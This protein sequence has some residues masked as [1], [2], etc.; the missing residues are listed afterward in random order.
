MYADDITLWVT[1]G[2]DAELEET[3][4]LGVHTVCTIAAQAGLA[5]SP[6]KSALLLL[7]P[8][9]DRSH[10]SP[11]IRVCVNEEPVPILRTSNTASELV[12]AHR[13]GQYERLSGSS[14]GRQILSRLNLNSPAEWTPK[15]AIPREIHSRLIV[16][17]LPRNMHPTFHEGR[18]RSKA[19][20]QHKLFT[21]R[22]DVSYV[23]AAEYGHRPAF[24]AV[25]V[26]STGQV[27]TCATI[28]TTS[29]EQAEEATI[30]LAVT[31][32]PCPK[33]IPNLDA[34]ARGTLRKR[35]GPFHSPRIHRPGGM[36]SRDCGARSA[37]ERLVGFYDITS[38][39]R[40]SRRLYPPTTQALSREESVAPAADTLLPQPSRAVGR[41][42]TQLRP[43]HP[44]TAGPSGCRGRRGPWA[45][46][47][48]VWLTLE[49]ARA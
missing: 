15:Q 32:T 36:D 22:S 26:T 19:T 35:V 30:A 38:H 3:L 27:K 20:T 5:C 6:T 42:A 24:E 17:P 7:H 37:R 49:G 16:A 44:I 34:S 21:H 9:R 4:K 41:C 45:P 1:K 40:L 48:Q 28:F 47:H 25:A 18:R 2:S 14:T 39:Y 46:G 12:E 31:A 8:P 11:N 10:T 43:D 33:G 29:P 13:T 23:D